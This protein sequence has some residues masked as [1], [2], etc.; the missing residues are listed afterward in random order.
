[1]GTRWAQKPVITGVNYLRGDSS[2]PMNPIFYFRPF[3]GVTRWA[4]TSYKW[5]YNPCDF[6]A[7]DHK[8]LKLSSDSGPFRHKEKQKEL[9]SRIVALG[10]ASLPF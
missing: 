1:M 6:S 5:S 3:I 4:L 7:S 2:P 10:R 9:M 8:G